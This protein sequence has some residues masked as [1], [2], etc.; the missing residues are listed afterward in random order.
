MGLA[1]GLSLIVCTY[2]RPD[3]LLSLLAS[4]RKQK[5]MPH[6][7]IIVDGSPQPQ[8]MPVDWP[9]GSHLNY[10]QVPPE[11]RGLTKQRN[12]G[13]NCLSKHCQYVAFLDDDVVLEPNY[14]SALLKGFDA[15]E[16]K[17]VAGYILNDCTWQKGEQNGRGIFSYDGYSRKEGM[18]YQLRKFFACYPT[19]PPAR[20]PDFGHGHPQSFLPPT[21]KQYPADYLMGG[22]A[23]YRKEIFDQLKFSTFFE[24]YGLYEDMDFSLRAS[25]LGALKVCTAAGL[26]HYHAPEGRPNRL[27]YGRMVLKNSWYV[28]KV[29]RPQAAYPQ[30]LKWAYTHAILLLACL[31]SPSMWKEALGRAWGLMQWMIGR[32]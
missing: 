1:A 24:G 29:A 3:S 25:Q 19:V 4:V 20:F 6:E 23:C 5:T 10:Y 13:L 31:R 27:K 9:E 32:G 11:Q 2:K 17:G 7:V 22:L 14:F 16:V 15:P 12:F 26:F 21:G 28:Y 30:K 8:Q 18:R